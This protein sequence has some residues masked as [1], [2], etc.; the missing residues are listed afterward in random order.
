MSVSDQYSELLHREK[1]TFPRDK[2]R[3]NVRLSNSIFMGL[4]IGGIYWQ[5]EAKNI[6]A[7]AMIAT[8]IPLMQSAATMPCM[9][10]D[11]QFFQLE[12]SAGLYG[13]LPFYLVTFVYNLVFSLFTALILLAIVWPFSGLPFWPFMP[14][15][16]LVCVAGFQ[17][18]DAALFLI[19]YALDTME[20]AMLVF[21][22]TIGLLMFSNG[23]TMNKETSGAYITWLLYLSPIFYAMEGVLSAFAHWGDYDDADVVQNIL[24]CT[25]KPGC[26]GLSGDDVT[27]RNIVIMFFLSVVLHL[28]AFRC[29]Q[30]MHIPQR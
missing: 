13:T 26:L 15:T 23:F 5:V 1:V 4:L 2:T 25:G 16:Y 12:R 3:F 19:V 20:K 9:F 30:T 8:E 10:R 29:L 6:S 22:F 21:N 24:E 17:M 11:R 28:I 18:M 27:M 14:V 7:F